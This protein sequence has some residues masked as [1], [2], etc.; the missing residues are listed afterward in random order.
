MGVG[1][2]KWGVGTPKIGGTY[3]KIVKIDT[4]KSLETYIIWSLNYVWRNIFDSL[5]RSIFVWVLIKLVSK[6][7]LILGVP[8]P[9][10][11]GSPPPPLEGKFPL[12]LHLF[13]CEYFKCSP[14]TLLFKVEIRFRICKQIKQRWNIQY[15]KYNS[16]HM[17]RKTNSRKI[18]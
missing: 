4:F 1:P 9:K 18:Y 17:G 3:H 6:V 7:P 15:T 8:T 10:F 13:Y 5:S 2:L 16:F 11:R 14:K 12:Y